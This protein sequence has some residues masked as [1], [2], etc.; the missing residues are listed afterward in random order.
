MNR[1]S[2]ENKKEISCKL[3]KERKTNI[4]QIYGE[5]HIFCKKES[6]IIPLKNNN[7][8]MKDSKSRRIDEMT[9]ELYC[10]GL[11]YKEMQIMFMDILIEK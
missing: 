8:E 6:F 3:E 2:R 4:V 10:N 1:N 9:F 11:S 5:I 7:E